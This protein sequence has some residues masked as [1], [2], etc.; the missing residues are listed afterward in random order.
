MGNEADDGWR[1]EVEARMQKIEM[2]IAERLEFI[3]P[4]FAEELREL[5]CEGAEKSE[6]IARITRHATDRGLR[7]A[8]LILLDKI[9]SEE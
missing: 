8:M 5:K 9:W 7:A 3:H 2:R 6:I 4:E 1:Q